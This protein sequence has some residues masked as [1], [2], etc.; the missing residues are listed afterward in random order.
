LEKFV[1]K[2]GKMDR[3]TQ[4]EVFVR[5]ADFASLT[6][7]AVS[8]GMSNAAASRHLAAL[9]ERLGTRLIERNTRR[10]WLTEAGQ[11][12]LARSTSLLN[13]LA[14]AE[15]AMLERVVSPTGT[16]KVT[17]SL[18][19][20][21][22]MIAPVLPKF[23]ELY[24]RLNVQI[25]TAN[26]YLDFIEAGI[27]VAVRTR[28]HE[29][30]SGI[31]VRRLGETPRLFAASPD[32]LAR[33]GQPHEPLALKDHD[34]LVYNLASEPHVLHLTHGDRSE[35]VRIVSALDSNDGQIL[36]TAAL[37]GLGILIQPLYIIIDDLKAGRLVPVLT[38]WSL[39]VLTMNI[40]YQ[41]RQRLPAKVR[42]FSD[43]LVQ[44]VKADPNNGID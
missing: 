30:D 6:R 11:E 42:V 3:L 20:A 24:P 16:L 28:E 9:E 37:A 7:A 26:R 4:I 40:A 34:M 2:I 44:H 17:S 31:I 38:D 5:T 12:F 14:E 29:P 1:V 32:Y 27:D 10:L 15:S 25:I 36:K 33:R 35:T 21:M 22:L 13:E 39:P 19:F 41:N 18:S 43:F 23:R 8:L